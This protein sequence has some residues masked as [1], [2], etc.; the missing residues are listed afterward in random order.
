MSEHDGQPRVAVEDTAKIKTGRADRG[1]E[2][3][4]NE[5]VEVIG[6]HAVGAGHIVRMHEYESVEV[7][8]GCPEWLEARII[9]IFSHDVRRN[10]GPTQPKFCYR[11]PELARGFLGRL[12]RQRCDTHKA[13]RILL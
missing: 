10:H 8:G 6:L 11:P 2:R 7:L 12:H 3:I 9:E 1:V 5:I 13:L 4:A